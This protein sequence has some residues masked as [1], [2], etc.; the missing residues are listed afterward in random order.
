MSSLWILSMQGDK[1]ATANPTSRPPAAASA[2][3]AAAAASCSS[4]TRLPLSAALITCK[5]SVG[6]AGGGRVFMRSPPL[7]APTPPTH[8]NPLPAPSPSNLSG[9]EAVA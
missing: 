6:S 7:S 1:P 9:G 4:F 5:S 3:V 2:A 8:P